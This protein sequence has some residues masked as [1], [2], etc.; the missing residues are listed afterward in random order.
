LSHKHLIN[1][2]FKWKSAFSGFLQ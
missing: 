1:I 2:I